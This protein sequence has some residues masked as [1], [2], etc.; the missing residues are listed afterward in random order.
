MKALKV[1]QRVK[2]RALRGT[3][4]SISTLVFA[5]KCKEYTVQLDQGAMVK[6][7][8]HQVTAVRKS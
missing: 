5:P 1:G 3:V 4:L 7:T 2:V 6:G 8:S